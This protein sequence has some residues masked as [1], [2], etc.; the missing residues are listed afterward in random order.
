MT[1]HEAKSASN[2]EIEVPDEKQGEP[3][4]DKDALLNLNKSLYDLDEIGRKT[5]KIISPTKSLKGSEYPIALDQ[6]PINDDG[7]SHHYGGDHDFYLS[8]TEIAHD[9]PP[10]HKT[11]P[12]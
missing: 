12:S 5:P 1:E 6:S 2:G 4:L 9:V 8:A 10:A 3:L 7:D 11:K